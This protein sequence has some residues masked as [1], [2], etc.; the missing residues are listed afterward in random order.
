[1][2]TL[3]LSHVCKRVTS[4]VERAILSDISLRIDPGDLVK[5]CGVV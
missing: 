1:M 2:T 5:S 3:E 4:P